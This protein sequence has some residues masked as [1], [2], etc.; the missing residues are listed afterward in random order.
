MT[1]CGMCH[2]RVQCSSKANKIRLILYYPVSALVTLFANILQNPTDSRARSDL[3][4]MNQV[5]SFLSALCADDENASVRRMLS[6]CSEFERIA[7]IVLDKTEKESHSRRKRKN[8][9]SSKDDKDKPTQASTPSA[10][11]SAGTPKSQYTPATPQPSQP[12]NIPNV[13]TPP[14]YSKFTAE[15]VSNVIFN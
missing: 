2:S 9:E 4:L 7:K 6:V 10:Q 8:I 14:D 11:T 5:V 12:G 13:F 1:A 3:K 15:D